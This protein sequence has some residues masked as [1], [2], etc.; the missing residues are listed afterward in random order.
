[1]YKRRPRLQTFAY[2]GFQRYFLTF[3]TDARHKV[4]TNPLTV[5]CVREQIMSAAHAQGFAILA[6]IFMPDHAHLL[7][8]GK[9]EGADLRSFTHLAKQKSGYAYSKSHHRR[10]WQPSYYDRVL[11]DDEQTWDAIRYVV[12]N[13]VRANLVKDFRQYAFLGSAVMERDELVEELTSRPMTKW[14]P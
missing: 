4:F 14:Q 8:E 2:T 10:L 9:S 12:M 11:R 3:C 7:V 1:M 13:P 6:Y 5:A